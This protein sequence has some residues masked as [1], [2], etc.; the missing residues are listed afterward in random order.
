MKY[1]VIFILLL[2]IVIF[3]FMYAIVVYNPVRDYLAE[4]DRRARL[5]LRDYVSDIEDY[6]EVDDYIPRYRIVDFNTNTSIGMSKESED[7]RDI[8]NMD[9]DVYGQTVFET[10]K[11]PVIY[12]NIKDENNN[13]RH[14]DICTVILIHELAHLLQE[15]SGH[16]QEFTQIEHE[17]LEIA[18]QMELI[19]KTTTVSNESYPA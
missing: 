7:I 19:D 3:W 16:D 12:I 15:K 1:Q 10:G 5:I 6:D 14:I 11:I 2:V 8:T 4:L 9:A 13:L 18:Y 17:L